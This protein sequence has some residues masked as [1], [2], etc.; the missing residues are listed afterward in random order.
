MPNFDKVED[1][2]LSADSI[3]W[4]GC[5]K[6]YVLMDAQQTSEMREYEYDPLITREQMSPEEM[7]DTIK[8]WWDD[9]C[10]LRFV[11]AVTS[12]PYNPNDGFVSL[13]SQF[14]EEDDDE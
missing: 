11:D 9:S 2:L 14:E 8:G 3:A 1:A 5:H 13:I 10:D 6:I 4:D 12:K 7:L